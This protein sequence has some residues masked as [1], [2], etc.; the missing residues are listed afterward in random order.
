MR[1]MS[2]NRPSR[3]MNM[4]IEPIENL[5][6]V[7]DRDDGRALLDGQLAQQVHDDPGALGIEGGGG[8]VSQDDAGTI[9]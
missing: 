3:S 9:G 6:V 1:T 4:R 8:L 7:G 2:S 5:L